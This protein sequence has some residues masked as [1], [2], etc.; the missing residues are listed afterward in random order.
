MLQLV[1][2]SPAAVDEGTVDRILEA[3]R[4]PLALDVFSAI[5]FAPKPDLGFEQCLELIQAPILMLY[6]EGQTAVRVP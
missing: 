2:S 3:T 4:Q 5:A 1:Y 6:G